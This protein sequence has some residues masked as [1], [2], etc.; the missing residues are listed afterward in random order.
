MKLL[1]AHRDR[2]HSQNTRDVLRHTFVESQG[3]VVLTQGRGDYTSGKEACQ[4]VC[5]AFEYP[6]IKT[7]DPAKTDLETPV[8]RANRRFN[9]IVARNPRWRQTE[10]SLIAVQIINNVATIGHVGDCRAYL[11]R[12]MQLRCVTED[13]NVL[14]KKRGADTKRPVRFGGT[15]LKSLSR[16]IGRYR[17]VVVQT[18]THRL[19]PGDILVLC[20]DGFWGRLPEER[21]LE[22]LRDEYGADAASL[23]TAA[24][25]LS[26]AASDAEGQENTKV[27]LIQIPGKRGPMAGLS[28]LGIGASGMA[29]LAIMAIAVYMLL[30]GGDDGSSDEVEPPKPTA[31]LLAV[32]PTDSPVPAPTRTPTPT[33]SPAPAST[34]TPT[35]TALPPSTLTR[36]PTPTYTITPVSPSTTPTGGTPSPLPSRIPEVRPVSAL[37]SL[38]RVFESFESSSD[39]EAFRSSIRSFV[40]QNGDRVTITRGGKAIPWRNFRTMIGGKFSLNRID[41]LG[42]DSFEIGYEANSEGTLIFTGES[43]RTKI[44]VADTPTQTPPPTE[45]PL[46]PTSTATLV[47]STATPTPTPLLP[48]PTDTMTPVPPTATPTDTP[49]PPTS[50]PTNTSTSTPTA[51]PTNTPLPPAPTPPAPTPPAPTPPA[52]TPTVTATPTPAFDERAGIAIVEALEESLRK[53]RNEEGSFSMLAEGEEGSFSKLMEYDGSELTIRIDEVSFKE[54]L[55]RNV[56]GFLE[57]G[58]RDAD[59]PFFEWKRNRDRLEGNT[60]VRSAVFYPSASLNRDASKSTIQV[61]VTVSRLDD[62][63]VEIV[64]RRQ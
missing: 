39:I 48:T 10:C 24:E 44:A 2:T 22:I 9:Q 34:Q 36:T 23:D 54:R 47:P 41:T 6:S 42:D 4:T 13:H 58:Q 31:N 11:F 27:V 28:W 25:R 51:T 52:L 55:A 5:E 64:I 61:Q 30:P 35:N 15:M 45:A 8:R 12:D 38:R 18:D 7:M 63:R 32:V 46:Q 20:N 16:S 21:M 3:L 50:T 60:F 29:T 26:T 33:N 43:A 53:Q 59:H 1:F 57:S 14:L 49:V 40:D 17:D 19:V 62:K 56:L 37:A